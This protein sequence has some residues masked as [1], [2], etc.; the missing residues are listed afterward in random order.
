MAVRQAALLFLLE[1]DHDGLLGPQGHEWFGLYR[2]EGNRLETVPL[3]DRRQDQGALGHCETVA[4][5]LPR[6]SAEG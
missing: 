3:G 6:A 4:D 2:M 1:G 5:A